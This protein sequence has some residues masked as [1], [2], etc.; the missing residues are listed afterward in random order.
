MSPPCSSY[1]HTE[2]A[3][4]KKLLVGDKRFDGKHKRFKHKQESQGIFANV[5]DEPFNPE[6]TVVDRILDVASQ[7][8]PNGEVSA[9]QGWARNS[10][11][12]EILTGFQI[13]YAVF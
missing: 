7:K 2:W 5:D 8:E 12:G 9:S 3:S 1:L 10:S 4:Y 13:Q 11:L 6:Y